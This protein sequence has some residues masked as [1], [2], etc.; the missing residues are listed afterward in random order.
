MGT[1]GLFSCGQAIKSKTGIVEVKTSDSV[2]IVQNKKT[3][4]D[5]DIYTKYVYIDSN[6]NDR[7]QS[8]TKSRI[9]N[10]NVGYYFPKFG[11]TEINIH[12]RKV[13][14]V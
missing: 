3:F 9:K 13:R 10:L 11:V 2:K 12:H 1:T 6:G 7:T 14:Y 5:K 8:N 4:N